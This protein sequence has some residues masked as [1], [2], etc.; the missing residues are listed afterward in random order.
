VSVKQSNP[1]ELILI[2]ED[3]PDI[4]ELLKMKLERE[5]FATVAFSKGSE[6]LAWVEENGLPHLALLDI[7]MPQMDGFELS[8]RL[9]A[10]GDVPI[11]FVTVVDQKEKVTEAIRLYAEDY[12]VKPFHLPELIARVRRVLSR[13]NDFSFAN[14]P[15]IEIDNTLS[16]DFGN[17]QIMLKGK[18]VSLTPTE[19]TLLHILVRNQGEPVENRVLLSR[20]WPSE[21][22]SEDVLRVHMHRLRRK[23]EPE[24]QTPHYILTERGVGYRFI[25][26][27]A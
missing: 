27:S 25:E 21:D 16:I 15:I 4:V 26:P 20:T 11:I 12:V 1:K 13:I 19:A 24:Q 3:D 2:V 7:N 18:A 8:K 17:S 10:R 6:V 23:L 14:E 22:K 5:G 9:K